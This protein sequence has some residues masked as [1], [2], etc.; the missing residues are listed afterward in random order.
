MFAF[1]MT[2]TLSQVALFAAEPSTFGWILIVAAIVV[3]SRCV[4]P[5]R[6][7]VNAQGVCR[8]GWFPWKTAVVVVLAIVAVNHFRGGKDWD[9]NRVEHL[10]E[11][12]RFR[13]NTFPKINNQDLWA[14]RQS[15]Q[16]DAD[17]GRHADDH[18]AVDA[19]PVMPSEDNRTADSAES[20]P[21]TGAAANFAENHVAESNVA[22]QDIAA[23]IPNV[24]RTLAEAGELAQRAIAMAQSLYDQ[25]HR[26]AVAL[27]VLTRSMVDAREVEATVRRNLAAADRAASQA[28]VVDPTAAAVP[29]RP[30]SAPLAP[31]PSASSSPAV[32]VAAPAP[33]ATPAAVDVKAVP[34]MAPAANP[35][36]PTILA[37]PQAPTS[38]ESTSAA[39]GKQ[40]PAWLTSTPGLERD[41]YYTT[42]VVGPYKTIRECEE[43]LPAE[44]QKA[45]NAYVDSYLGA[46]ASKVVHIPPAYIQDHL[47]KDRYV[48][49]SQ[50][51]TPTVGAMLNLYVRLGFDR[52]IKTQM[53]RMHG[54]ADIE[55]R[56]LS[57]AGGAGAVLLVLGTLFGYLKL[58]TMTRGYY[59]RRLQ[60]AAAVVILTTVA[61]GAGTVIVGAS[62]KLP[63][64]LRPQTSEATVTVRRIP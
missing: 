28:I 4:R 23:R 11:H 27:K 12:A 47:V 18:S 48:Q 1:G 3:V 2:R 14:L 54:D 58:D 22:A 41:T 35:P 60:F 30:V 6:R 15:A 44:L 34:A 39:E 46:G 20:K 9:W 36:L 21:S 7:R 59:T 63:T 56:L 64:L 61:A 29:P 40:P 8:R 51:D 53:Q 38:A 32:L 57:V 19:T 33:A 25:T 43:E 49:E 10:A 13:N 45:T 24:A 37:A 55:N 62:P 17:V 16:N 26:D 5:S 52:R 42:V 31:T 50:S